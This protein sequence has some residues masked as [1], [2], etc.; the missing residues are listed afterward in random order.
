MNTV[1]IEI[2]SAENSVSEVEQVRHQKFWKPLLST[3]VAAVAAL[4][5]GLGGLIEFV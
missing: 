2:P 1:S 4:G 3:A 5:M